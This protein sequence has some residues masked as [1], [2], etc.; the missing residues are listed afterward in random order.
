MVAAV[1]ASAEVQPVGYA[2][3]SLAR[4]EWKSLPGNQATRL[5]I[6]CRPQ[7]RQARVVCAS[8]GLQARDDRRGDRAGSKPSPDCLDNGSQWEVVT[9]ASESNGR[10]N[11]GLWLAAGLDQGS[12]QKAAHR[13]G[14]DGVGSFEFDHL[15]L[16]F[17]HL[18]ARERVEILKK[19]KKK[20]INPC[21]AC[22]TGGVGRET[23]IR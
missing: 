19:K 6:I 14:V 7:L 16:F 5:S 17:A 1:A 12:T 18:V 10:D 4:A 2:T 23:W 22:G 8:C 3:D 11:H 15:F 9:G 21:V 20:K 13:H